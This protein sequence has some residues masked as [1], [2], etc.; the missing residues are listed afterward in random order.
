MK[1]TTIMSIVAIIIAIISLVFSFLRVDVHITHET[2]V[3]LGV[4]LIGISSTFI[5]GFQIYNVIDNNEHLKKLK[6]HLEKLK[7]TE[8]AIKKLTKKNEDLSH[9]FYSIKLERLELKY[10]QLEQDKRYDNALHTLVKIISI[11]IIQ[12]DSFYIKGYSQTTNQFINKYKF[13]ISSLLN[14]DLIKCSLQR[15]LE[16][17]KTY[18]NSRETNAYEYTDLG[19][20]INNLN[21][22]L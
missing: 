20:V 16:Q 18:Q 10:K 5:V 11:S 19:K 22:I 2:F 14:N 6:E 15:M 4:A 13:E 1:K 3:G 7:K 8:L 9:N 12:K 21:E 17:I